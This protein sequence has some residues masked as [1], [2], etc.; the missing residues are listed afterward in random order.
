MVNI[1]KE[2][3]AFG[4][5][6]DLSGAAFLAL[7]LLKSPMMAASYFFADERFRSRVGEKW[8][9]TL[10]VQ[11]IAEGMLQARAGLT[12]LV[13]GFSVQ[14]VAL[15]F[16]SQGNHW[17]LPL[18]IGVLACASSRR[19]GTCWMMKHR[20]SMEESIWKAARITSTVN[21]S[22]MRMKPRSY[23]EWQEP[24]PIQ[25]LRHYFGAS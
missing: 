2:L 12:S 6:L 13:L 5:G 11:E 8:I 18:L 20:G 4:I 22:D 21:L 10:P 19:V 7:G 16:P 14:L 25:W 15:M 3:A 23:P 24:R 17:G 9:S 1:G